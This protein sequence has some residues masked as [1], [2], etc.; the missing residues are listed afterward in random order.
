MLD[1]WSSLLAIC[2]GCLISDKHISSSLWP[3]FLHL[4]RRFWN[5]VRTWAS[6]RLISAA[7]V[8]RLDFEMYFSLENSS[9]KRWIC[10]CEN[11]GLCLCFLTDFLGFRTLTKV[12]KLSKNISTWN[13]ET[14]WTSFS[15]N[16]HKLMQSYNASLTLHYMENMGTIPLY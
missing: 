1:P 6:V 16:K 15:M 7:R 9:S 5:Q 8:E 14:N 12:P 10:F 2:H 4:V 13:T 3:S 11:S